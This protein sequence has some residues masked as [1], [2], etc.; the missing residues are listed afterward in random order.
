M[1]P[2]FRPPLPQLEP[3]GV[4]GGE[5][6]ESS[7]LER[8]AGIKELP[9]ASF[10]RFSAE[11]IDSAPQIPIRDKTTLFV[12]LVYNGQ[13]ED[14]L[15][16]A[17]R[18]SPQDLLAKHLSSPELYDNAEEV[19]RFKDAM[20]E[21][22]EKDAKKRDKLVETSTGW[23]MQI[24]VKDICD[25]LNTDLQRSIA[26]LYIRGV[27]SPEI[28]R[29]FDMSTE[30]VSAILSRI[31][32]KMV[33]YFLPR[34]F[35]RTKD[36]GQYVRNAA[37]QNRLPFLLFFGFRYTTGDAVDNYNK[38]KKD[39]KASQELLDQGYISLYDDERVSPLCY[40]ALNSRPQYQ[41]IIKRERGR[42]YMKNADL[43]K[44]L[45]E[46]IKIS[47][48]KAM[49]STPGFYSPV[50][51]AKTKKEYDSLRDALVSG[52]IAPKTT[53]VH[54]KRLRHFTTYEAVEE[55]RKRKAA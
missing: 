2:E 26:I 19:K 20:I 43:I 10:S 17:L 1:S 7:L 24:D 54:G 39:Q 40:L 29:E 27:P 12:Y 45:E 22:Y 33:D 47:K 6:A 9:Y 25:L 36:F 16:K 51:L 53:E 8:F 13:N 5:K 3:H 23:S 28:A 14:M 44:V 49:C 35:E 37:D 31:R 11:Y 52:Q 21:G 46:G 55:W 34:E 32:P 50:R 42:I 41:S 38:N 4:R 18:M 15:A 48:D 30:A